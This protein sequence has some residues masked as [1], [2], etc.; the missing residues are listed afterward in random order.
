[1][2][3]NTQGLSKAE[4]FK[5]RVLFTSLFKKG[6]YSKSTN[7]SLRLLPNKLNISRLGISIT[8]K[9]IAKAACRSR[10]KRL[11]REAFRVNKY[12][13]AMG[14]DMLIRPKQLSIVNLAYKDIEKELL[15]LW[16]RAGVLKQA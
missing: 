14:Y 1:M 6:K 3:K 9:V 16:K 11:I 13:L 2:C 12:R 15:N 8:K 10:I 7:F 5:D 4:R